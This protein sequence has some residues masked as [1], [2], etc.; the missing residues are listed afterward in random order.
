MNLILVGYRGCGKSTV[1]RMLADSLWMKFVDI[2]ERI[3]EVAKIPPA[4][5]FHRLGDGEFSRIESMVIESVSGN[6]GQVI[7]VGG[8]ALMLADNIER[9][10]GDSTGKFIYLRVEPETLV[11]RLAGRGQESPNYED[12]LEEVTRL[13]AEREPTYMATAD[14]VLDTT[15]LTPEA[16]VQQLARQI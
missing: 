13:L 12:S 6:N 2:D 10:R 16:T 1:G 9:L 3:A 14:V 4:D 8:R 11:E 5:L 15:H 7:S